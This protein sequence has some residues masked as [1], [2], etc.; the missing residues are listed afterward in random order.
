MINISIISYNF[1]KEVDPQTLTSAARSIAVS[2]N[3]KEIAFIAR[4]DV[5]VTSVE[6][7]TTK[8]ITDTPEQERDVDF[9]PDGR[10]LVYSSERGNTWNIYMTELVREDDKQFCYARELKETRLTNTTAPSFDPKFSPDGKEIAYLENRS[11]IYVLNLESKKTR[12]VMDE[13]FNY[14]YSDGDQWFQW[15]PDSKW[16]ISDYIDIGGWNNKDVALINA[17][18]SE[19]I[20]NL[21]QSGY[22]DIMAKWVLDGGAIL[23]FSDRAGYRS[24]GSWGAHRDAYLMFLTPEAHDE[25]KMNKEERA[26]K[27]ELE[28]GNNKK[29]DKEKEKDNEKVKKVEPLRFDLDNRHHRIIRLTRHSSNLSDAYLNKDGSKLYYLARFEKGVDLWE[30]DFLENSTKLISK[31]VGSGL[32]IPDKDEKNIYLV[33]GGRIKKIKDGKVADVS[34]SAPFNYRA[35][36]EREYIFDHILKQM[37]DK[38]YDVDMHGVDWQMYG[39]EYRKFLPHIDNNFDF[40]EMLSEMLGELNASH[41]G[42]RYMAPANRWNTASLGVFYDDAYEG[43]GLKIKEIIKGSPLVKADSKFKPGVVIE[44]IDG[45]PV[46][47]GKTWWHLLNGKEGRHVLIT[48]YTPGEGDRF[49]EIVKPIS[50]SRENQLLYNRWVEQR[51]ELTEK[52]SDGRI[53]YVHVRGMDSN[54]FREVYKNLLGKYR[55]KE[56]VVVDTRFNSGGWL[57]DDLVTLLGGKEYQRFT[58]RGQYIGSD[59]FNKWNK[60]SILLMSEGNYSNA[61]GFPWLYKELGIGKLV[62]APVPGTMTAVWWES[63]IDPSLVFG[64]PQVTVVN[65]EGVPMENNQL[66]PDIEVYNTPE[67]LLS[68]DDIQLKTAVE[69]LLKEL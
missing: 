19:E 51:E 7:S 40:S 39:K 9:S 54:S 12:K 30:Q 2:P 16:I 28:K 56:A 14:S 58:P 62:G 60:P 22:S 48:A 8:R 52:Y 5:F 37:G 3:G 25:F 20:I 45:E 15:S 31:D 26:L 18:G 69:E 32:L 33:A 43:D 6:F 44:K 47:A 23:F 27:K 65:M 49:E 11:A 38:F 24:H 29:D 50:I 13:K 53:G 46:E 1:E 34:F 4:G 57:H 35:A 42:A 64:I 67:S 36:Q 61:H 59:P 10:S 41:T 55:N 17:G 63:Q 66:E 21:T 68:E